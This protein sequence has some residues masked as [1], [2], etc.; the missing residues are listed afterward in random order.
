[1]QLSDGACLRIFCVL[2]FRGRGGNDLLQNGERA[3]QPD[4]ADG[5]TRRL[6]FASSAATVSS[7]SLAAAAR[8]RLTR[9][10]TPGGELSSKASSSSGL[11]ATRAL[12]PR[13]TPV[14]PEPRVGVFTDAMACASLAREGTENGVGFRG[15]SGA[16]AVSSSI[17][18]CVRGSACLMQ[19][20]PRCQTSGSCSR[21]RSDAAC[22][23]APCISRWQKKISR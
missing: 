16:E 8:S 23:T 15:F 11:S 17:S 1:M 18:S 14:V 2:L 20:R 3:N 13:R 6:L 10:G 9:R 21:P 19:D 12:N 7:S 4:V 22:A 5:R